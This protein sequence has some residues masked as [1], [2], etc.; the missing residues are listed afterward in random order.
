MTSSPRKDRLWIIG[1]T[2]VA[3]VLAAVGYFALVAPQNSKTHD[4]QAETEDV[5]LQINK[6]NSK[7]AQLRKDNEKLDEEKA[8]L[9]DRK[10]ALPSESGVSDYLRSLETLGAQTGVKVQTLSISEAAP[11]SGTTARSVP[12]TML[13]AGPIAKVQDFIDRTLQDQPRA[14][15]ITSVDLVPTEAEGKLSNEVTATISAQMF[16]TG[17]SAAPAASAPAA[18][19][20]AK[21]SD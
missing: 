5:L 1:G 21:G 14:V 4:R 13:L 7:L 19:Q 12:L 17:G 3:I 20:A 8:K 9:A 11:V 2:V 18:G 15:L 10:L 6:L 16:V